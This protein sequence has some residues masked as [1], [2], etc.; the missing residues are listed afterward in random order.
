MMGRYFENN[1]I[2]S[3]H[4][5]I[6]NEGERNMKVKVSISKKIMGMVLLPILCICVLV[7]IA[8]SS[9]LNRTITD[10]IETQLHASAYN[11]KNEYALVDEADFAKL[12]DEFKQ[13]N[14][15][16]VTIFLNDIR[17]LSTV[18]NA[19]GTKMSEDVLAHI[20]D[21]NSYFAT[22]ANVNGEAYFA[23][24]IPIMEDGAYTGAA[25]TGIPQSEAKSIITR[26][27]V[28][29]IAF[30]VGCGILAAV[31]AL[32]LIKQMVKSIVGL[33]N[34]IGTLLDND[35]TV[36]HQKHEFEHDEI[37]EIGNKTID[38]A[39]NL[40]QIMN[41]IKGASTELKDI[42]TN[43][44][45]T[46]EITND[47][48]SQIS[49][50]V[51]NVAGGALS[52]AEDTANAAQSIS[53]MSEEL[54]NIKANINDLHNIANS[55]N[56]AK[57]DAMTTLVELKE[58]NETMIREVNSTSEQVNA[59]SESVNEIKRA[60]GMIQDIA[61]QTNLLSLN[62]SIEAARAGEHGKG[63][64]VVAEE[65]GELANQSAQFSDEIENIL[66]QLVKN[67]DVIIQNVKGTSEDMAVQDNRLGLTEN[68]FEALEQDINGTVERI[69]EINTM[70]NHLD[71]EIVEMVDMVSNLSAI[72]EENSASTEE[73]MASIQELNATINQLYEKS[74]NVD[75]NADVLIHEVNVFKTL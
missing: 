62:A 10:E 72:S 48:C 5:S 31:V 25:F 46:A 58:I 14:E 63:F 13:E 37:E 22:N 69:D 55:M 28:K 54:G 42:A 15:M 41:R 24:Y 6:F 17:V 40:N 51:E 70:I 4:I 27:V 33:E 74:Q 16:D 73:T 50:A 30:V 20:K 45:D 52:Q 65:I 23:Y 38:F 1:K 57:N 49:E 34:T 71:A 60:V 26:N 11:F 7:G 8:S 9:I 29:L 67:Y 66:K 35:L 68:V 32:L 18:E 12:M 64:A 61:S 36:Q 44:K 3:C 2:P 39:E 47:T 19:V 75:D 43:L 56:H 21:G 59:T 53:A